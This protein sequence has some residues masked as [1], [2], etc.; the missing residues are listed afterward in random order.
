MEASTSAA[1]LPKPTT[2]TTLSL[3][4]LHRNALLPSAEDMASEE[5]NKSRGRERQNMRR[6]RGGSAEEA[7]RRPITPAGRR[8]EGMRHA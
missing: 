4:L 6:K 8:V 2:R 3:L 5:G 1:A 7:A